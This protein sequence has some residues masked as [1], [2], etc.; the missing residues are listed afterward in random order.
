M[1]RWGYRR[2]NHLFINLNHWSSPVTPRYSPSQTTNSISLSSQSQ[3]LGCAHFLTFSTFSRSYSQRETKRLPLSE[4]LTQRTTI[5]PDTN[6]MTSTV[7]IAS[8]PTADTPGTCLYVHNEKHAY[9]FGRVAEGTQ[10]AFNTTRTGMGQTEQVFLTGSTSWNQIGGLFGFALTVSG[11]VEASKKETANANAKR[12]KQGQKRLDNSANESW[13]IHGGD[14]LSHILAALRSVILRQAV[15]LTVHE[16]REDPRA[17]DPSNIEPDWKDD[18]LRVWKVPVHRSRSSSPQKRRFASP[19]EDGLEA[20]DIFKPLEGPSDP[21]LAKLVVE[22]MMFNRQIGSQVDYMVPKRVGLLKSGDL[23]F[24]RKDSGLIPYQGPLA[25]TEAE[26]S[27]PDEIV[28]V[29]PSQGDDISQT[30]DDRVVYLK[31][32]PLPRTSYSEISMSYIVKSEGRRGKFN[33]AVAKQLGVKPIDF[34]SLAAGLSVEV[35][36]GATVTPEMVLGDPMPGKGFIVADIESHDFIDSFME[37]PEWSNAELLEDI[38]MVYWILGPGLVNDPR[39]QKFVRDHPNFKHNFTASD[40]CPNM[41]SLAGP[42]EL[43]TQLRVIDPDRFAL[44]KYDNA[45][46]GPTVEGSQI[47]L[48]RTGQTIKLMP[49]VDL[50]STPTPFPN[51]LDAAKTVGEDILNIAREAQ[52]VTSDPDFLRRIEEEEADIPNRDAEII[53]LGTG[54]SIP[55][56]YRNVSATLIRV[57]GLGN[58]LLDCGEGTLGQ[59][60]RL[61]G[62]EETIAILRDLKCIAISHLHADHHLGTPSLVKAWY[63]STMDNS[64]AKLAISCIKKYQMLLEEASQIEDIGYHRLRFVNSTPSGGE[65]SFVTAEDMDSE[66]NLASVKRVA[67]PH[68]HRSDAV[69]LELT[70]GLRIAY[71]GDCR[72]SQ[73]FARECEGAHLLIHE[74]TFDDD[75]LTHAK[76]KMHSTISEALGVAANMK[77]RRTLLTHFSQRYVKADSLSRSDLNVGEVL[78]A[79][80]HMNVRLGDFK[81]AAAFQSAIMMQLAAA[82]EGK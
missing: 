52:S 69:Q 42:A 56:K 1:E 76:K 7:K 19:D 75:M 22:K 65:N 80:D 67:V 47:E 79:F 26:L 41:I 57:P 59:I 12:E 24:V 54:S 18:S 39:I 45:V 23:A 37:R 3:Q 62:E 14:N 66:F 71:S 61:F 16:H 32:M 21:S 33:A 4:Y 13:G 27:N 43:Q 35:E 36:G 74:C 20:T 72:P 68:C 6:K 25:D 50:D 17:T 73:N 78:M 38:V 81:K 46:Q 82:S 40:T 49:R 64:D 55:G 31:G 44:L 51:L 77:A 5:A 15:Y 30:S 8:T 34:R 9:V 10:R 70:S 58:Y 29:L 28:W 63:E 53:P 2:L 60:R 48:G 11:A